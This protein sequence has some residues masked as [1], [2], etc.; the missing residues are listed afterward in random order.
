MEDL[1]KDCSV[2]KDLYPYFLEKELE[3]ETE[4]WMKEHLNKC[5]DCSD[6]IKVKNN[7][8]NNEEGMPDEKE[9]IYVKNESDLEDEKIIKRAKFILLLG[10]VL[11]IIIGIWQSMWIIF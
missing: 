4:E 8:S 6:W 11:V 9:E 7:S 10:I 2:F 1:K 3:K 5:K